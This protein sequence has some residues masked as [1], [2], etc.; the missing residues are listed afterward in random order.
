MNSDLMIETR[1]LTKSF[2]KLVAV[3]GLNLNVRKGCIHGFVG[4]NGAGKTTTMKMLVGSIRSTGGE[5]FINGYPIGSLEARRSL[6]FSPC[7][8]RRSTGSSRRGRCGAGG[9]A[10]P[11]EGP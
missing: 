9:S 11:S 8:R 6:G 3:N 4:P 2:G 1:E 5:G 7:R 10:G